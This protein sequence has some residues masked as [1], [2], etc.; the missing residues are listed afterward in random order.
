MM[1]TII[2]I[3]IHALVLT[4]GVSVEDSPSSHNQHA[5][6]RTIYGDFGPG[7]FEKENR[8]S[9]KCSIIRHWQ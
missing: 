5:Q 2:I 8:Q 1:V 6:L 3:I 9:G 4:D 7:D